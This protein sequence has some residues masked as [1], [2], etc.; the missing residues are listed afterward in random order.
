MKRQKYSLYKRKKKN[1]QFVYYVRFYSE[2]EG[3]YF[4]T[5]STG[6]TTKARAREAA[7]DMLKRGI[8]GSDQD[9]ELIPYL[10]S[11]WLADSDYARTKRLRGKPL[12]PRYLELNQ[13]T[14]KNCIEP[15]DKFHHLR[16]SQITLDIADK[17]ILWLDENG[18]GP[19]TINIALQAL[20][21]AGR[22]WARGK[23]LP[24]PLAGIEKLE[25]RTKERGVL[26][27]NEIDELT[28]VREGI[29]PRA[30]AAVILGLWCALRLGEC[31]GL[32]WK[33]EIDED[34]GIKYD[35]DINEEKSLIHVQSAVPANS[36]EP[37][38]PKGGSFGEV[39]L[40]GFVLEEIK[41]LADQSPSG[42]NGY[43]LY[44][45]EFN[46]PMSESTI[47]T[48][49]KKMLKAIKINEVE[50]KR[51][52]LSFHSLRHTY[53][54]LSR[55]LGV[56]DFLIQYNVRHKTAAMTELYTH[57]KIVDLSEA[58]KKL[59]AF[60]KNGAKKGKVAEEGRSI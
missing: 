38:R 6:A 49:F 28:E 44:S 10:K 22:R 23:R 46:K 32:K 27:V 56:Q 14:I 31:R 53:V 41:N 57:G 58:R 21:V 43:V 30:R 47:V 24:D 36:R 25:E 13:N 11:F 35:H 51:R 40:P 39:P 5:V 7:D 48:G 8:V 33:R 54:S 55:Y 3:R 42:K 18:K 26:S 45:S 50:R 16:V 12:S 1:G 4:K 34:N 59:E 19:R 60:K 15:Y 17:W 9:P 29:D 20:R 37:G 52:S 2:A